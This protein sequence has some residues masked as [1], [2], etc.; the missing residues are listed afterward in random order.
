VVNLLLILSAF[1]GRLEGFLADS[2]Q[3]DRVHWYPEQPKRV[4]FGQFRPVS[5]GFGGRRGEATG[6]V[7]QALEPEYHLVYIM[8]PS[9]CLVVGFS[10]LGFAASAGDPPGGGLFM[11]GVAAEFFGLCGGNCLWL[12]CLSVGDIFLHGARQTGSGTWYSCVFLYPP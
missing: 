7:V 9:S 12:R 11:C 4:F 1:A 3:P 6:P 5:A 10:C 8:L 2:G